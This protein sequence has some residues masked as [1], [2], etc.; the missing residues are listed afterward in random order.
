MTDTR[1][2]SLGQDP[3]ALVRIEAHADEYARG[4]L[5]V[6]GNLSLGKQPTPEAVPHLSGRSGDRPLGW[7]E[8]ATAAPGGAGS[9]HLNR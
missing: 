8:A 1:G 6:A 3:A 4:L 7:S 9:G 5:N 2:D